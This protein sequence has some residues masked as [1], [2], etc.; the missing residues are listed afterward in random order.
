LPFTVL[1]NF[2]KAFFAE[3]SSSALSSLSAVFRESS[4]TPSF[5]DTRALYQSTKAF[6]EIIP[7]LAGS[8]KA[9]CASYSS[10]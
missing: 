9:S 6:L 4:S 8:I 5:D 7:D 10:P 3:A 1:E 2:A